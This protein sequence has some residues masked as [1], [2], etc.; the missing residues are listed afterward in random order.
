VY[1]AHKVLHTVIRNADRE[2][3]L[4]IRPGMGNLI[5]AAGKRQQHNFI[6]RGRLVRGSVCGG[7]S[8]LCSKDAR[9]NTQAQ[10]YEFDLLPEAHLCLSVRRP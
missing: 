9:G 1:D 4:R 7:A 6:S 10:S 8:D 2:A 3:T 5:H